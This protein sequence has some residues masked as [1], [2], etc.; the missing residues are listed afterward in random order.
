MSE[1]ENEAARQ[2]LEKLRLENTELKKSMLFHTEIIGQM[3]QTD[4]K[5]EQLK[6]LLIRAAD[7]LE[8]R[9]SESDVQLIEALRRRRSD[10][11]WR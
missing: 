10:A 9:S 3:R 1:I 5:I 8:K 7:A 6:P 2:E 4:V 11:T